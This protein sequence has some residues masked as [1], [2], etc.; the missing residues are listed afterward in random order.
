MIATAER[1]GRR[2]RRA[3]E[4]HFRNKDIAFTG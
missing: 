3:G 1:P 2:R 4:R